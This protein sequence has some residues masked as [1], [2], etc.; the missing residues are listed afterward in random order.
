MLAIKFVA[1]TTFLRAW[2]QLYILKKKR[3]TNSTKK[4][5]YATNSLENIKKI[6]LLGHYRIL[7]DVFYSNLFSF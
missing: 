3:H 6:S 1:P 4:K 5:I 2:Y 7:T